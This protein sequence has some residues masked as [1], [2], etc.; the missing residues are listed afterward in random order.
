MSVCRSSVH[1]KLCVHMSTFHPSK[2]QY[3]KRTIL[4]E[5][6]EIAV[7]ETTIFS[8]LAGRNAN[9]V[10]VACGAGFEDFLNWSTLAATINKY[11]AE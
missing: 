9:A 7:A 8:L 11:E 5:I 2:N 10:S 3:I 4:D 1:S 6:V